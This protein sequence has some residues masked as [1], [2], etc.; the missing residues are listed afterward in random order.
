MTLRQLRYFIAVAEELHFGRAAARLH[1][2]QP[3]LSRAVVE[4]E[5]ELDVELLTRSSR[6]VRLTDAGAALLREAPTALAAV[7]RC[8][9]ITRRVAA[10]EIGELRIGFLPSVTGSVLPRLVTAFR[11]VRPSVHLDLRELLDDPLLESLLG[12]SLDI[13]IVRHREQADGVHFEPLT[14]DTV[15]VVLPRHHQLARRKSL[16]YSE[17]EGEPMVLWPRAYSHYGYDDIMRGC[18]E[19]GFVPRI[20]QESPH[21][22]TILGLVAAGAGVSLLS[23][24]FAGVRADL[25]FVP[26]R[27]GHGQLYIGWHEDSPSPARDY[28]LELARTL[29]RTQG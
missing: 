22:Y 9:E 2:A 27:G 26:L 14:T 6:R 13:A 25:A 11:E 10:G 24:G 5:R 7:D 28:F 17:L 23:S 21:P 4:L 1:I 18:R 29:T 19:A 16:S 3:S 20:V 8:V 15:R 12:G